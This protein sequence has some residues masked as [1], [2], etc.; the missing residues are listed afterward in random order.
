MKQDRLQRI[1]IAVILFLLVVAPLFSS[2]VG[3]LVDWLWF[4]QEGYRLIYKTILASQIELSGLGGFAVILIVGVN[5]LIA[6]AV[7]R[8]QGFRVYGETIEFPA[9]DRLQSAF[10]WIVWVGI[11]LIGYVVG[12]WSMTHWQAYLFD[13][14]ALKVGQSDPIFHIDIGFYLFQLDFHWFLY[15]LALIVLICC[16]LSA[17]FLYLIEGGIW[18]TQHGPSIAN[19]VRAHLLTLGGLL[20]VLL[21]YRAR[22]AMY[23]V[24]FSARGIIYGAGYADVHGELPVLD[25]VIVLCIITA[26]AFFYC[27]WRRRLG[28]AIWSA[29]ALILVALLGVNG[30]P[31]LIEHLVVKPNEL[32]V[33]EPYIRHAIKFT[34]Q[35]YGLDHFTEYQFTA[36]NDLSLGD[37]QTNA[38]TMRNIRLWDHRPLLTTYQQLQAIR[39]YYDFQSVD[40]DRYTINGDYR[41]V[42][43]SPR[44]L[45]TSSLPDQSW[46]NQ[47]LIYTHG[48]GLCLSPV[49]EYTSDGLPTFLVK[50]IPP[51]SSAPSLKIT[52]PDIYYGEAQNGYCFVKTQQQEFDYPAGDHDVYTNYAGSGG[53]L[54]KSFWRRLLFTL[55]FGQKNIL[56]STDI[57]NDSRL[58][59]YRQILNRAQRLAPFLSFDSDPYIVITKSGQLE[60]I[61]DGYTTSA[62][63]PY[64][65]PTEDMGNYIRNSVK[66]TVN[67]YSGKVEFY[68]ADPRDPLIQAWSHILP[69]VFHPLSDMPADL[70]AHIRYPEGYFEIQAAKYAVF[71]MTD[72]RVFYNKE[73]L[74]V[75]ARSNAHGANTPMSPYYTILR[76]PGVS[77]TEEFVLMIPFTP[78][79]KQNM[80]AWMAA[81]CDVPNYGHVVV[82]AFPKKKL[83]YG[84]QQIES[85]ID[86]NPV[87]SQQ[88]S[89]WDQGGSSVIRGLLLVI[90]VK[91]SL[92]YVEP[93][94]LTASAAG[95]LPQLSRVIVAYGDQVVM[96]DTLD[97]A[98]SQIFGGN[99]STAAAQPIPT[100][101][102]K[103]AAKG[104]VKVKAA[105]A[106]ATPALTPEM[107]QLIHQA[108]Q[109]YQNAL[110]AQRQGDW[111]TYGSEIKKLGD[112]INKLAG[113][114]K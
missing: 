63:Y 65:D 56:F 62:R 113:Q 85:R 79:R 67:A 80:I 36:A 10:R 96:Q 7:S 34:R 38:A 50:D 24:L 11:L 42:L 82:F 26:A 97:D 78:A 6:R 51:D 35:A 111:S 49:N 90:P 93:L 5:L 114:Q 43:L 12:Q 69:G 40:S 30:Y 86:Q 15:H 64:S 70:R 41:Q 68:I 9:L 87:I 58:M 81:R 57:H 59:I 66:A 100:L 83:I 18:V 105:A 37:I 3:L 89:L 101:A 91:N 47:H 74:W 102:P 39:T 17:T 112:T 14:H 60:W 46:V 33:E 88:L 92:L 21:A 61:L 2:G 95:G 1:I 109:H 27:A 54:L 71:H 22:L 110:K 45:A 13:R 75:V 108:N 103:A 104:L 106:P 8:R 73:D 76:L 23:N 52:Q 31:N 4:G 77:N 25:I 28:P 29:G 19:A 55:R 20:F 44:E 16:L 99:V 107:Q 53:I 32:R 84:P 98:L 94:Y 72:P 48:Y